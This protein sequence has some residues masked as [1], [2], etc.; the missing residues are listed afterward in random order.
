M[1]TDGNGVEYIEKS[2]DELTKNHRESDENEEG[3]VIYANSQPNCPVVSFKL[4]VSRL[5]PNIESFF[6][7]PKVCPASDVWYDA[8]VLGTKSLE[9]MMKKISKE[10][11]LSVMYTNHC[12][13]ATAISILDSHGFEVR[14]IMAIS[15]HRPESS[16]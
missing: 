14:H 8:Q 2:M 3:G 5:N 10:A 12:I 9:Q 13:R 15:G 6:Q 4:Y 16:I 7:R 1:K 11:N